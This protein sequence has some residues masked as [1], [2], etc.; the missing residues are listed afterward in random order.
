MYH[1]VGWLPERGMGRAGFNVTLFPMWK[2]W[3]AKSGIT[4]DKVQNALKNHARLWLDVHGFNAKI[5]LEDE[6][7]QYLWDMNS[8]RVA[9][10]EWGPESI[11]VP[12]DACD[13]S[14]DGLWNCVDGQVL[15][16][17]NVDSIRQASLLLTVFLFFAEHIVCNYQMSLRL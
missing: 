1:I 4:Q 7:E 6:G 17:H 12:G 15:Y 8:I 14:I 11:Q 2:E 5:H 3:V 10:G 13:L 9:W 16:P